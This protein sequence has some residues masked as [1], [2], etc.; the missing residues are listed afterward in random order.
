MN[1]YEDI[2]N[3]PHHESKTREQMS[4]YN[5]AAQFAPYSALTGYEDQVK[6][7]ARLTDKKIDLD[8]GLKLILNKKISILNEHLK[9][10]HEIEITYFLKD[11]YKDGGKYITFKGII[12]RIDEVNKIIY[13]LDRSKLNFEDIFQIKCETLN[14]DID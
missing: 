11:N 13:F 7:T 10:K 1:N 3:L 5:R 9:E 12:R 8:D 4:L 2:I 6:E 14:L